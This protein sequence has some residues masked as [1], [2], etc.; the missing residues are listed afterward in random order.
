MQT[1]TEAPRYGIDP[2]EEWV[3]REG[4]LH[5]QL[6]RVERGEDPMGVVRDPAENTPYLKLPI[7]QQQHT[8]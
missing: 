4:I 2:Y 3:A 6:D 5:E 8:T 1:S 7:E